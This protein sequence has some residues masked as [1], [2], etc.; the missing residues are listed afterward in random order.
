MSA[1]DPMT[2]LEGMEAISSGIMARVLELA[3][4][5]DAA[6]CT[7]A[8]ARRAIAA[9]EKNISDFAA[10]L[11]PAAAPLL[12]EMA[13]A[14]Q[15]ETR[16]RFGNSVSLFTPVYLSNHCENRCVY[17]GFNARNRIG[18]MR[19]SLEEIEEE[20]R[21]IAKSGLEE[22]LILTGESRAK[23]GVGYIG[24]A[25]RIARKHFR[26]VGIEIYPIDSADYAL[27]NRCGADFV[28]VFQETYDSARYGEVHL[29]GRKR[30]F[31][32]RF[33]AQERALIGGFRGVGFAALLGLAGF[34]KDAF[35]TGL[36]A[37]FIQKNYPHAEIAFSCPRLRPAGNG[38][39]TFVP[40]KISEAELL[41][42]ICA[43][44]LFMPFAHITISSRES[45]RFRD[46]VVSI[47]ATKISAGV[48]VSVGG[49]TCAADRDGQFEI[50]DARSVDE[51][52]RM[53][54]SKKLQPVMSD[55][56]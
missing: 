1:R 30:V 23:S 26:A 18:R 36:H 15:R 48:N 20:M 52:R 34:R 49:H 39:S 42:V 3:E 53:L 6:S 51:I 5:Y 11:S 41:Q 9:R 43:Y 38:G 17:C 54:V 31:P 46:N 12:E 29:G 44:R 7:E 10:L 27:L 4:S 25:C 47:A 55:Y 13:Q 14:A 19:L 16:L 22:I 32:Y 35:A 50:D 45:A 2:Y 8:R 28:T 21:A 24:E 37:F 56:V 40:E 33:H